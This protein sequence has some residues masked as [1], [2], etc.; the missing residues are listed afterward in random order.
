MI[1]LV[2]S[3][4][5]LSFPGVCGLGPAAPLVASSPVTASDSL[6]RLYATGR[7]FKEFLASQSKPH[8]GPTR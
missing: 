7:S 6:E 2:L 8:C 1:A 5:L 3:G 4:V